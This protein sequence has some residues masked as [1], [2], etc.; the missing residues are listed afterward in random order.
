MGRRLH[1]SGTRKE[2]KSPVFAGFLSSVDRE[3]ESELLQLHQR[4]G[5]F[6]GD[7]KNSH[8]WAAAEREN[9]NYHDGAHPFH[10][11][12]LQLLESGTGPVADLG[13]G[14]A[15][16][17]RH[18]R[19]K[20]RYVGIDWGQDQQARNRDN[21]HETH[22]ITASVYATGLRSG[23]FDW[24][25]SLD[26]L[27]HCVFP[28]QFLAEMARL[29]RPGGRLAIHC[30][31]FRPGRMN[32]IWNGFL[33]YS[34]RR[35]LH[36]RSCWD[37]LPDCLDRYWLIKEML[38]H[39]HNSGSRFMI[40]RDPR[41]FHDEYFYDTDAVYWTYEP[42]IRNWLEGNAFR[43]EQ[44]RTAVCPEANATLYLVARKNA[45]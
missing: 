34:R 1:D 27:E 45:A 5:A 26:V 40:Y 2:P 42:E 14:S 43:I 10:V 22:F 35:K 24:V 6:Y 31:H 44:D 11:H 13:C 9:A 19:D 3:S 41:C 15:H 28:V 25:V 30:P 8:Y 20:G 39:A 29:V 4:M 21:F 32:S 36:W 23:E 33:P 38:Q 18:L 7:P 12:L 17:A 37:L 16:L